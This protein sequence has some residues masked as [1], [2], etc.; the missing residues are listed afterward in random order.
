MG[1]ACSTIST[2]VAIP[3]APGP[4]GGRRGGDGS[5]GTTSPGDAA[6]TPAPPASPSSRPARAGSARRRDSVRVDIATA[7]EMRECAQGAALARASAGGGGRVQSVAHSRARTP[8]GLSFFSTAHTPPLSPAL[9]QVSAEAV[10]TALMGDSDPDH[11]PVPAS[12][13]EGEEGEG[14]GGC[15]GGEG[16][17]GTTAVDAP[18]PP[19]RRTTKSP[20]AEA[21]IAA[22]MDSCFL[23]AGEREE[24]RERE[25]ERERGRESPGPTF[26][27]PLLFHPWPDLDADQRAEVAAAMAR[28]YCEAGDVIIREGDAGDAFFVVEAGRFVATRA[29]RPSEQGG[30]GDG[31]ATPTPITLA[32][33]DG[34]GAFGELA[35]LYGSPRAATVAALTHGVLWAMD[36]AAFRATLLRLRSARRAGVEASLSASPLLAALSPEARA[37]IADCVGTEE[38]EGGA[39]ILAQGEPVTPAS[40]LYLIESGSVACTSRRELDGAGAAAGGGGDDEAGLP[41]AAA[42]TSLTVGPGGWFGEVALVEPAAAARAADCVAVGRVRLLTL[43]R[44]AFERVMGPAEAALGASVAAYREMNAAAEAAA[45]TKLGGGSGGGGAAHAPVAAH[46]SITPAATPL[47]LPDYTPLVTGPVVIREAADGAGGGKG[48]GKAASVAPS[49]GYGQHRPGAGKASSVKA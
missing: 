40:K 11:V 44:D 23:F 42:T 19:P 32:T 6:T 9:S 5:A 14:G 17:P 36:R 39:V 25:R 31:T 27:P 21:A 24:E 29:A 1:A 41:R 35:L 45:R 16:E 22:A 13:A 46:L 2:G 33:Y 8:L 15:A 4:A 28:T 3:G 43:S 48:K 26:T 30:A 18:L 34:R 37:A 47:S 10:T 12:I 38:Y 20:D 49:S 7:R